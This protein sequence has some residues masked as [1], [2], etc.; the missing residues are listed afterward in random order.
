MTEPAP[1]PELTTEEQAALESLAQIP[2]ELVSDALRTEVLRSAGATRIHRLVTE[3][4]GE[5]EKAARDALAAS[6]VSAWIEA[7]RTLVAIESGTSDLPTVALDQGVVDEAF[8]H[9]G[10]VLREAEV[11]PPLPSVAYSS[12][13]ASWRALGPKFQAITPPP[14]VTPA[15][16]EAQGIVTDLAAKRERILAGVT[17]WH[18]ASGQVELISSLRSAADH[19]AACHEHAELTTRVTAV[20]RS[21]NEARTASGLQWTPPKGSSA[22]IVALAAK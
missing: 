14:L 22:E 17:S 15:D 9:G 2:M 10:R 5:A 3:A 20:V 18:K 1:T 7:R 11:L 16:L 6:D 12:Q 19:A 21:A 4:T 8:R 13:M